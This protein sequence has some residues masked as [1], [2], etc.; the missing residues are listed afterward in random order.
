MIVRAIVS[1][2]LACLPACTDLNRRGALARP[3]AQAVQAGLKWLAAHQDES[4][5]WDADGFMKH[6]KGKPTTGP[7][8]AVHDVGATGLA[9]LAMLGD[10]A[11][12]SG[13]R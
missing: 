9:M 2:S 1:A 5:R 3:S 11:R 7:G 13:L 8:S 10:L 6:D 4:G 12:Y